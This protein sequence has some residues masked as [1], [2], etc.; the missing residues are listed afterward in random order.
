MTQPVMK[1]NQF[2]NSPLDS[3]LASYLCVSYWVSVMLHCKCN[4]YPTL[5]GFNIY[6]PLKIL[7]SWLVKTIA[8]Q[9]KAHP[10]IKPHCL[11]KV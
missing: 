4:G 1:L 9:Y 3:A 10:I 5:H 11:K 6:F 8:F 2:L 7:S